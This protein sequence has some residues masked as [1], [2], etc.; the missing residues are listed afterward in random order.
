MTESTEQSPRSGAQASLKDY[1]ID[2]LKRTRDAWKQRAGRIEFG[3]EAADILEPK[4]PQPHLPLEFADKKFKFA[5]SKV[6]ISAVD[7][8]LLKDDGPRIRFDVRCAVA[9]AYSQD[10]SE[11][12]FSAP[13]VLPPWELFQ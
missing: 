6:P 13:V 5:F 11:P 10:D 4:F 9:Y 3:D 8:F 2:I 12:W 7:H 1:Q